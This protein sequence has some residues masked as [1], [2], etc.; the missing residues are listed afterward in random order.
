MS[1]GK[2]QEYECAYVDIVTHLGD[3]R[4]A[5]TV[6]LG[7]CALLCPEAFS[8]TELGT[9]ALAAGSLYKQPQAAG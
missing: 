9:W 4:K 1:L 3:P 7:G 5:D 2:L 8:L 6:L